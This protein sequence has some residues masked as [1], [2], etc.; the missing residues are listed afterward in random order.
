[1]RLLLVLVLLVLVL[2]V[3]LLVPFKVRVTRTAGQTLYGGENR[4]AC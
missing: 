4:I 2:L 1:M 3:L